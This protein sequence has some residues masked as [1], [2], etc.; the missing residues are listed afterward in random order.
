MNNNKNII[1][2]LIIVLAVYNVG[3]GAFCYAVGGIGG[4]LFGMDIM[5]VAGV[6]GIIL[7]RNQKSPS[8]VQPQPNQSHI[9]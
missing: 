8:I 1:N 4:V 6:I 3:Y 5:M 2:A 7:S 9:E